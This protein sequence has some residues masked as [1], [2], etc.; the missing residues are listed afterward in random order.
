MH[1]S[2][3]KFSIFFAH[4][5]L[6]HAL[7]ISADSTTQVSDSNS[8]ER[9]G[10]IIRIIKPGVFDLQSSNYLIRM[11]AWGVGFPDRGQPGYEEALT[12]SE[13]R[14]LSLSPRITIK[15]EFD[16]DNLKV[17]DLNLMDGKMNFSR[18]AI[19][20]GIGWHL[21]QETGRYGPYLLA[22]LKSKRSKA[23]IWANGYNHLMQTKKSLGPTPQFPRVMS[24]QAEFVPRISY[25]VTSLGR[26]HRPGCSFYERGRGTLSTNPVGDDCRI[27]GGRSPTK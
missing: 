11:R 9:E 10:E 23:G 14:L 27:C 5:F 22:Q 1:F 19:T 15:R 18:E 21:E 17:V 7:L 12:F 3:L 6:S 26:I 13:S 25:W 16:P 24:G 8:S 4:L 2:A 20:L